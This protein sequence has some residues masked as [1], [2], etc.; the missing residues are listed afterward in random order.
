M[1]LGFGGGG[2]L[3]PSHNYNHLWIFDL[4]VPQ[5]LDTEFTFDSEIKLVDFRKI[6]YE[7]ELACALDQS[8]DLFV[9]YSRHYNYSPLTYMGIRF[10]SAGKAGDYIGKYRFRTAVYP[11]YDDHKVMAEN[12]FKLE[13]LKSPERRI[14]FT[15]HGIIPILRKRN[16]LGPFRPEEIRYPLS[17]EY[18]RR[19][20]SGLFAM[21]YCRY[22]ISMPMDV[23]QE[24]QSS[25]GIGLALRNQVYFTRFDNPIRYELFAGHNFS[26]S[27]DAGFRFGLNTVARL[28]NFGGNLNFEINP[29]EW[30]GQL[31]IQAEFGKE[32]S[33]RPYLGYQYLDSLK[34]TRA[35]I[36]KLLFGIE[37][38]KFF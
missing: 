34:D 32:I 33:I 27:F 2:F 12:E 30:I 1:I 5:I 21:G 14:L 16:F 22:H 35:S 36:G 11:F 26:H 7:F 28:L 23:D 8:L 15:L 37:L 25:L 6:L 10:K 29:E 4:K 38:I 9:R 31:E 3:G 20:T 18:L 17:L 24:F 13:F 19:I